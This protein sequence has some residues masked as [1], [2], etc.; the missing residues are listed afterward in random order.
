MT[1]CDKTKKVPLKMLRELRQDMIDKE[2]VIT[3]F[4]FTFNKVHCCVLVKRYTD[5][6]KPKYALLKLQFI[7]NYDSQIEDFAAPANSSGL[8][9][10]NK[11]ISTLLK[12]FN[13][14]CRVKLGTFFSNFNSCLGEA[15]PSTIKDEFNETELKL[16]AKSLNYS[17]SE[18]PNKIYC[19]AVKRNP[20]G[21]DGIQKKRSIFNDNK[22]KLLRPYLYKKFGSDE[23]ISFNYSIK[24][25]TKK[26]IMK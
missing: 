7:K 3:C 12:F 20:L 21:K 6:V 19:F 10:K 17:E 1:E 18:D 4:P 11:E 5:D 13:I 23:T 15:V 26:T 9:L 22:T 2:W 14:V 16:M 24:K 25:L 8:M